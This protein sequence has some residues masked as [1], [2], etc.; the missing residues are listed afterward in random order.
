MSLIQQYRTLMIRVSSGPGE[1][2]FVPRCSA[3]AEAQAS[4]AVLWEMKKTAA[5]EAWK[6]IEPGIARIAA[7]LTARESEHVPAA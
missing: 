3:I 2:A 5:R 7:I 1:F 6:E 4:G